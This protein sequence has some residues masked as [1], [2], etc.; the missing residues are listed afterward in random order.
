MP[1]IKPADELV[2]VHRT[3]PD[4]QQQAASGTSALDSAGAIDGW[5]VS[6][7]LAATAFESSGSDLQR[8]SNSIT[9]A[10]GEGAVQ[11]DWNAV[12]RTDQV[13]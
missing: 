4:F 8:G 3:L 10:V 2:Q 6:L 7:V 9:L 11:S 5:I 13:R 12:R 1:G